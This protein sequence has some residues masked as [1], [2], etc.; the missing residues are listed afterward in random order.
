MRNLEAVSFLYGLCAGLAFS[1]VLLIA[2]L[3]YIVRNNRSTP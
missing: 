1:V 2:T 3:W